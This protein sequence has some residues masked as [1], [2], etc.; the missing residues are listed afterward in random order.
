MTTAT[1]VNN[2]TQSVPV[3]QIGAEFTKDQVDLIKRTIA[4][5]TTDD[6]LALFIQQC[7][8]T[9]LDPF[10]RQIYALKQW[11]SKEQREVMRIQT[12]IDGFRLIADRTGK[13]AGQQG[14]WWCGKDGVWKDVWL[15]STPP[16]AAR[17]G[18]IRTD[19]K[20]PLYAIARYDAYVQRTKSGDP[21][22][23]WTKMSD[24]Q[25]AKCA[26]S[27]AL[28]KAFPGETSGL[29]TIEELPANDPVSEQQEKARPEREIP[30]ASDGPVQQEK[31]TPKKENKSL[32]DKLADTK[33]WID[34]V[35][36]NESLNSEEAIRKLTSCKKLWEG[37]Y[38]EF[39]KQGKISLY[40]QGI[41]QF[42]RALVAL[43][44]TEEEDP[45]Q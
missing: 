10:N 24:N 33:T 44:H 29:Y 36:S 17:V 13:Y 21:N 34:G 3:K 28:R 6:E 38:Q 11:D 37:L 45:F 26:E 19:F 35:L 8:R 23:I 5:G 30:A 1:L 20:E 31:S 2:D 32:E 41:D 14:P 16:V 18:V 7:K 40:Q 4:K 25:L 43:G 42:D 15:E 22:M 9:G 39:N 12:S 27:L